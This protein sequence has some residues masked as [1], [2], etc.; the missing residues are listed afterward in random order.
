MLL[1]SHFDM[2]FQYTF[3]STSFM[4]GTVLR[5]CPKINIPRYYV[6]WSLFNFKESFSLAEDE[7]VLVRR[8][9]KWNRH[10]HNHFP[11]LDFSFP[12]CEI[13]GFDQMISVV[14]SSYED[15][16][17]TRP[18]KANGPENKRSLWLGFQGCLET[19]VAITSSPKYLQWS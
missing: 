7:L 1:W 16:G 8:K 13:S 4:P 9:S 19:E 10:L 3:L 2:C 6:E 15:L 12:T 14:S 11:P 5:G 18:Y 17:L